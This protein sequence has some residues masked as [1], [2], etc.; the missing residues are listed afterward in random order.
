M[1]VLYKPWKEDDHLT[2]T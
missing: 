2:T 1:T